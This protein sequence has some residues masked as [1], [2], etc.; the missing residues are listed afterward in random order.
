MRDGEPQPETSDLSAEGE[1]EA[2][3]NIDPNLHLYEYHGVEPHPDDPE[4]EDNRYLVP[5]TKGEGD[6]LYGAYESALNLLDEF[7]PENINGVSF[8]VWRD[9]ACQQLNSNYNPTLPE[10][11]PEYSQIWALLQCFYQYKREE[12]SE[13]AKGYPKFL[14]LRAEWYGHSY[15]NWQHVGLYEDDG[16]EQQEFMQMQ[17]EAMLLEMHKA[18]EKMV[19]AT[20]ER[21]ANPNTEEDEQKILESVEQDDEEEAEVEEGEVEEGAVEEAEVEYGDIA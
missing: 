17:V 6:L 1:P 8:L 7:D 10:I 15:T 3:V 20:Q 2:D 5:T 4:E 13:R 14:P 9:R 11:N 18:D 19:K 21:M 16:E 12:N